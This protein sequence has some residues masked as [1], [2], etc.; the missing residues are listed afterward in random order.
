MIFRWAGG[1]QSDLEEDRLHEDVRGDRG[2]E[3]LDRALA[4]AEGGGQLRGGEAT[5]RRVDGRAPRRDDF[6]RSPGEGGEPCCGRGR[7]GEISGRGRCFG[8]EARDTEHLEKIGA[9]NPGH[10]R[11][12]VLGG[13]RPD[14][15]QAEEVG[16]VARLVVRVLIASMMLAL[17]QDI[18]ERVLEV[19]LVADLRIV[20]RRER[21]SQVVA[22]CERDLEAARKLAGVLARADSA[23]VK[24]GVRAVECQQ[25]VGPPDLQ[26]GARQS[27]PVRDRGRED[28]AVLGAPYDVL[29]KL[30]LPHAPLIGAKYATVADLAGHNR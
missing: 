5:P 13:I 16:Q 19:P 17:A 9:K 25:A 11:A 18:E 26:D 20:R 2:P 22:L 10:K 24:M 14:R 28:A 12:D 4:A 6:S 23:G 8:L 27:A 7:G 29:A 21:G 1:S 15:A 30:C 3:A